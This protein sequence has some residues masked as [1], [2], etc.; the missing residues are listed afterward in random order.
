MESAPIGPCILY[1]V[2]CNLADKDL[3]SKY[4]LLLRSGGQVE[5]DEDEDDADEGST[6]SVGSEAEEEGTSSKVRLKTWMQRKN[7]GVE[8]GD[9]AN[10]GNDAQMTLIGMNSI[11]TTGRAIPLI[12]Q[13]HRLMHLW[14]GGNP[15]KVDDYLDQRG[16]LH[17]PLFKHLLQAL[18]EMAPASSEERALLESISNHVG[19]RDGSLSNRLSM[20]E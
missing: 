16:L 12:D 18:I 20:A 15:I 5:E 1:A 4:D 13:V 6:G 14:R 17:I 7:A 2:S 19:T 8:P 3:F 10:G 11:P 9:L